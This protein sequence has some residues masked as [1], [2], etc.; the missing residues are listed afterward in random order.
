M[1]NH[2]TKGLFKGNNKNESN[3]I[4]LFQLNKNSWNQVICTYLR[5]RIRLYKLS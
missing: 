5:Q 4:E 2:E 3:H 1:L